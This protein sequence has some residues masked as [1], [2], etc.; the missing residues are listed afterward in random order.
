MSSL[1]M[2]KVP[3]LSFA[4]KISS[5]EPPT[6]SP[7][8]SGPR[9]RLMVEVVEH[10]APSATSSMAT[11]LRTLLPRVG[12]GAEEGQDTPFSRSEPGRNA[13]AARKARPL[14]RTFSR[15]VC[16]REAV[17]FTVSEP[18][19]PLTP[20]LVEVPHAGLELDPQALSTL[21]A[22]ARALGA[23]ADLYVD[24]LYADAPDVGA[25]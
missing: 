19:A 25:A 18:R 3:P 15:M 20:V 16:P 4:T 17:P 13:R 6:M 8:T 24:E 9:R 2:A 23:D 1:R 5:G 21:A 11:S 7:S 22:S 14:P 10:P 12:K